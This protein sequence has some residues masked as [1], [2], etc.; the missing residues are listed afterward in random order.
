MPNLIIDKNGSLADSITKRLYVKKWDAYHDIVTDEKVTQYF[1]DLLTMDIFYTSL[2]LKEG[3]MYLVL[4]NDY[5]Q[6]RSANPDKTFTKAIKRHRPT[7][8]NYSYIQCN[9]C[10][11]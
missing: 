2:L 9:L 7:D 3:R 1:Q 8:E 10:E 4:F 6:T 11:D 5:P